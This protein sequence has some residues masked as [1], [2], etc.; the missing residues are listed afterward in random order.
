[1]RRFLAFSEAGAEQLGLTPQQHQALL[2]I[3]AHEGQ[4]GLSIGALAASLLV[5]NHSAVGLVARLVERGLVVRTTSPRD[6]RRIVLALTPEGHT[7]L[8]AISQRNLGALKGV[9]GVLH[10]LLETL[11][12]LDAE[13]VLSPQAVPDE[14]ES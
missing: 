1:M 5:R 4:E 13:G 9:A 8:E 12:R 10:D 3:R 14:R 7:K 2:A 11:S 6:R